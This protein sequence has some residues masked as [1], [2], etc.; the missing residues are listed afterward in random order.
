[1]SHPTLFQF[2]QVLPQINQKRLHEPLSKA[3]TH[4][5]RKTSDLHR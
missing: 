4:E 1:M 5:Y 3:M 2:I